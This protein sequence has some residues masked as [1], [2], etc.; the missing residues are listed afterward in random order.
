MVSTMDIISS[1]TGGRPVRERSASLASVHR[2][3]ISGASGQHERS[4]RRDQLAIQTT[5]MTVSTSKIAR[6]ARLDPATHHRKSM[7]LFALRVT[8]YSSHVLTVLRYLAC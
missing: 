5:L 3:S 6:G 2:L 8:A 7:N 4:A 1:R